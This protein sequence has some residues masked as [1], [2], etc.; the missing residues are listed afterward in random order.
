MYSKRYASV[1]EGINNLLDRQDKSQVALDY[2]LLS[3]LTFS[4]LNLT[5]HDETP[6][7]ETPSN[8]TPSN[9][10]ASET[11]VDEDAFAILASE[12]NGIEEELEEKE[13]E[14]KEEKQSTENDRQFLIKQLTLLLDRVQKMVEL[15]NCVHDVVPS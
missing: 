3:S 6:S 11:P 9:E 4:I 8:E 1:I 14:T 12:L 15:W 10:T 7:G 5:H 2:N 13:E